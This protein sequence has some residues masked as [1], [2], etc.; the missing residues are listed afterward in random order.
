M[1]CR[2]PQGLW[3]AEKRGKYAG[4]FTLMLKEFH[5]DDNFH[6][7]FVGQDVVKARFI[8]KCDNKDLERGSLRDNHS[9]GKAHP[10]VWN[11]LNKKLRHS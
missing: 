7:R 3:L 2:I 4:N 1:R 8:I 6:L 9:K 5:Q 11:L 10:Y